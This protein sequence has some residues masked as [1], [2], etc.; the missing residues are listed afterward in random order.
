MAEYDPQNFESVV[1]YMRQKFGADIF[2]EPRRMYAIMCDLSP[3][4]KPYGN[5]MRQL[6][7][8]GALAELGDDRA[9]DRALMKARY[10]LEN[11]LLLGAERVDYFMGILIVLYGEKSAQTRKK[12]NPTPQPPKTSAPKPRTS[13][14][15]IVKRGECGNN[16]T[17]TLNEK[18][19]LTIIGDGAIQHF[20]WSKK[21]KAYNAPWWSERNAISSVKIQNGVTAI[22][23]GAF[24]YCV[25]L[26]KIRIPDSVTA[27]GAYAF[28]GCAGLTSVRIPNGVTTIGAYAFSHCAG[29]TSVRIPDGVSAIREWAFSNCAGLTSVRIPDGVTAIEESAFRDC[30]G[31]TSVRIPDSVTSIGKYAF[32]GCNKLKNVRIPSKTEI[33]FCA[34]TNSVR[35]TRRTEPPTPPPQAPQPPAPKPQPQPPSVKIG[36]KG[37]CGVGVTYTLD[38]NGVL[39]IA[40]TG[41][42]QNF[43]WDPNE[44]VFNTPWWDER[45]EILL[46]RIQNGV[47]TVGDFAFYTCTALKSVNI[48]DSVTFIGN[49]A[50][51]GCISLISFSVPDNVVSIGDSAFTY[52]TSLMSVSVPAK[53]KIAVTAFPN[54][55]HVTRRLEPPT[56]QPTPTPVPQPTPRNPTVKQGECGDG[57]TYTL[58]EQGVLTITGN[59]AMWNFERKKTP[60]WNGH[61][62][63]SCVKIQSGVTV[64]GNNAFAFCEELTSVT[65]PNSVT[66]IGNFTFAF[67]AKVTSLII[68]DSVTSIGA[69]AFYNCAGLTSVTI[70]NKVT[71]IG[72][73]TFA[74]CTK[75]TSVTIPESVTAIGWN[76]FFDCNNLKSV[77]IPKKA[78]IASF[79]CSVEAFPATVRVMRRR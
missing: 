77:S 40:G 63:I 66:S 78:K 55:T 34:F 56:P 9:R 6:S 32:Y 42:M 53:A 79:D 47:T 48:P 23:D 37:K 50:F 58:D 16:V 3:T 59:G 45:L 24:Y 27:I 13:P 2:Q 51:S 20:K 36:K 72:N 1:L 70:P 12:K 62:T 15:K 43:V 22:G 65:I 39:T 46:V 60:W 41:P 75:L 73:F 26:N 29:L 68:P 8:R 4:L 57:V 49:R 61:D 11:E 44:E 19:V 71:S 33:G 10:V 35:E 69:C 28:H 54:S 64:I 30:A 5:V 67:C 17:Y 38:V 7:E 74:Y 21:A 76:A 14:A 25:A 31:L 18:G 52:C